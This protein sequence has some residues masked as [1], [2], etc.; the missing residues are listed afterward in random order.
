MNKR[1]GFAMIDEIEPVLVGSDRIRQGIGVEV[2]C[3]ALAVE[4]EL[5][6]L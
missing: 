6:P 5:C 2:R 3:R 1:N 4:S